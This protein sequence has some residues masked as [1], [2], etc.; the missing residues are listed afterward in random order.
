MRIMTFNILHCCNFLTKQI[1][2]QAFADTIRE[3][4]PDIVGLNEVR[5]KGTDPEYDR[6]V[7]ILSEMTGMPYRYFAHATDYPGGPYGNGFLSKIPIVTAETVM[8]PDPEVKNGKRYYETR[9]ILKAKLENGLTVLVTHIGLNSDE[10]ENAVSTLVD[11]LAPEKCIVMGDFNMTPNNPTLNSLREKLHDAAELFDS[12]LLSFPSP[13]PTMKLD[14]LLGT[15]DIRFLWADI[16]DIRTSDHRPHL[17]EISF[18][19]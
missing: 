9:A 10:Q 11:N 12:P 1:D 2:F 18:A 19:L 13:A 16:P 6:Q 7:E 17:A 15:P 8:I 14:Y 5:D 4:D 3:L